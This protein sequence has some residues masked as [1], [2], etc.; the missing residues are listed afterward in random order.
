L[1]RTVLL[2]SGC[3]RELAVD[4]PR[5][6]SAAVS[7]PSGGFSRRHPSSAVVTSVENELGPYARE[8]G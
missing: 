7:W 5:A 2:K 6:A 4:R 1:G 3:V 8:A